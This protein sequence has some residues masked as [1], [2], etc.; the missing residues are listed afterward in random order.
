MQEP[1]RR[2]CKQIIGIQQ[3][4]SEYAPRSYSH[5]KSNYPFLS[6]R[7]TRHLPLKVSSI[8]EARAQIE[9]SPKPLPLSSRTP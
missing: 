6:K 7:S 3:D 8:Q 4:S 5:V 1:Q 2:P 9:P